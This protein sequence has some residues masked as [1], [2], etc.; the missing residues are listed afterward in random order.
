MSWEDHGLAMVPLPEFSAQ[1]SGAKRREMKDERRRR[2]RMQLAAALIEADNEAIH[3]RIQMLEEFDPTSY[4]FLEQLSELEK[5]ASESVLFNMRP[6]LAGEVPRPVYTYPLPTMREVCQGYFGMSPNWEHY[7]A[8]AQDSQP[9]LGEATKDEDPVLPDL[10]TRQFGSPMVGVLERA[11]SIRARADR[12]AEKILLRPSASMP[13]LTTLAHDD[14][15]NPT[16]ADSRGFLLL[17]RIKNDRA[18]QNAPSQSDTSLTESDMSFSRSTAGNESEQSALIATPE[19]NSAPPSAEVMESKPYPTDS[20]LGILMQ[21]PHT[22]L[23]SFRDR[24]MKKRQASRTVSGRRHSLSVSGWPGE[25]ER[26]HEELGIMYDTAPTSSEGTARPS[27]SNDST[28]HGSAKQSSETRAADLGVLTP[29]LERHKS[30]RKEQSH[31]TNRKHRLRHLFQKKNSKPRVRVPSGKLEHIALNSAPPVLQYL[32]PMPDEHVA[33]M[34][35]LPLVTVPHDSDMTGVNLLSPVPGEEVNLISLADDAESTPMDAKSEAGAEVAASPVERH[36]DAAAQHQAHSMYGPREGPVPR[37]LRDWTP[38]YLCI[39]AP[40]EGLPLVQ[41]YMDPT[42]PYYVPWGAFSLQDGVVL[43][44]MNTAYDLYA[45]VEAPTQL[46]RLAL[47]PSTALFRNVLVHSDADHEGWGW[48]SHTSAR[49]FFADIQANDDDSDDEMPLMDVR[50]HA[51]DDVQTQKRMA[52]QKRRRRRIHAERRRLRALAKVQGKPASVYGVTDS[53]SEGGESEDNSDDTLLS[54][55]SSDTSDPDRPW[56]DDRRPAGRL[57]GKS[58]LDLAVAEKGRLDAQPR[59]YGQV[60]GAEEGESHAF[61]ND[62]KQRMRRLFGEQTLYEEEAARYR[63]HDT[64]EDPAEVAQKADMAELMDTDAAGVVV[65]PEVIKS[66]PQPGK[67]LPPPP[68]EDM[69]AD[70]WQDSSSEDEHP[71]RAVDTAALALTKRHTTFAQSVPRWLSKDEED[72]PLSMV[73]LQP[74]SNDDDD[75]APLGSLHPQAEIIAEKEATIRR[76]QEEVRQVRS[77]LHM[78]NS[79]PPMP[80]NP[81]MSWMRP[82]QHAESARPSAM[83]EL[84]PHD[85]WGSDTFSRPVSHAMSMPL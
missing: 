32:S 68:L 26:G 52:L 58:L 72:V 16:T 69:V 31:G 25:L 60:D 83:T 65:A 79:M 64:N 35:A 41:G 6:V 34:D 46:G 18:Q 23:P 84:G 24:V 30:I 53:M 47:Y 7:D 29:Y 75:G 63:D 70:A 49:V 22:D 67:A 55:E 80:M 3:Q 48:E 42:E 45:P 85:A 56:V 51:K 19:I 2:R 66:S 54:D 14:D 74:P 37:V 82:S 77:L 81:Y 20:P 39:P 28:A 40:L 73:A 59:Y 44:A 76:L 21:A 10:D 9:N 50:L 12:A 8:E 57:Y 78:R 38:T 4:K 33:Q 36:A 43:P 1:V 62:T 13:D 71:P 17:H 11:D 27:T 15:S 5:K 61:T